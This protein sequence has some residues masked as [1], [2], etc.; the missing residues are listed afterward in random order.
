MF[1]MKLSRKKYYI[2]PTFQK[3]ITK[4]LLLVGLFGNSML[5]FINFAIYFHFN[6]YAEKLDYKSKKL[7][8]QFF[9]QQIDLI[10]ICFLL[11]GMTFTAFLV[12][13]GIRLTH[14]MV[15]PLYNLKQ[16]FKGIQNLDN[17]ENI[18]SMKTANFRKSDYFK[19]LADEYNRTLKHLQALASQERIGTDHDEHHNVVSLERVR[20]KSKDAA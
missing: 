9:N 4:K 15:G 12:I 17:L 18:Q 14:R 10:N 1:K 5:Y 19:D 16:Q 3:D 20:G 7:F 8:Y 6:S 13:Y 11:M 2:E